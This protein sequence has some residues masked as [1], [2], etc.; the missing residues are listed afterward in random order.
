MAVRIEGLER[1]F[2]FNGVKLPDPSPDFTVD[3]KL[4]ATDQRER[5]RS[6]ADNEP[7][8]AKYESSNLIEAAMISRQCWYLA[9]IPRN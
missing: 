9:N 2:V 1:L 4:F 5:E 3:Q 7:E 8:E 6:Q